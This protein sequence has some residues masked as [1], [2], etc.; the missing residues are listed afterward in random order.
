MIFRFTLNS[1]TYGALVLE[2][3]PAGWKDIEIAFKRSLEYHGVF[4]EA[5]AQLEFTC[6]AGKEY[7]DRAIEEEGVD[8]VIEIK[9]QIACNSVTGST[10]APDYSIDYSDDYGSLISGSG[11]PIFETL[12][13]GVLNLSNYKQT[14]N[15]TTV[16][17]V[18][19]DFVQKVL[20]R[21]DTTVEITK[22]ESLDGIALTPISDFPSDITLHSK[23]LLFIADWEAFDTTDTLLVA[24]PNDT[25]NIN[26]P[27][28]PVS[29]DIGGA[30]IFEAPYIYSYQQSGGARGYNATPPIFTNTTDAPITID[31]D[32][33][34]NAVMTVNN[35]L[36]S[37]SPG[38]SQMKVYLQPYGTNF[39]YFPEAIVLQ[40]ITGLTLSALSVPISVSHSGTYTIAAGEEVFFTIMFSDVQGDYSAPA[41]FTLTSF[42]ASDFDFKI[43]NNNVSEPSVAKIFKIHELGAAL[44]QRITSQEDAFR[45]ELLGRKN[46]EPNAYDQN[47]CGAFMGSL[48]GKLIRGFQV[49]DA[50]YFISMNNYFRTVNSL[51]STGL[52]FEKIGDQYVIRIE[53]KDY[54]Y[55]NVS[56]FQC[57]NVNKITTSVAKEYFVSDVYIGYEKWETEN[58]NGLDEFN[59]KRQY[60]DGVKAIEGRLNI[61]CPMIASMYSIEFARR[62]GVSSTDYRYDK[63][64]FIISLARGVDGSGNPNQLNIAEKNENFTTATGM[65]SPETSYNLRISP[66]R[67]LLWH[68]NVIGSSI[69]KF[70]NRAVKF[71]YGEGNFDV[72]TQTNNNCVNDFQGEPLSEKQDITIEQSGRT[73]I[74][75]P[76]Y[77]DFEYP[78]RFSEFLAIKA[79]PFG[80]IEASDTEENYI[81][82]FIIE[83]RYKPVFG[84]CTFRLL[85]KYGD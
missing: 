26:I 79:A 52:S 68:L 82:G 67:N 43:S 37:I 30:Q 58:I 53:G 25:V 51:L 78:L 63:D 35:S 77:I 69:T 56:M 61:E 24:A 6:K 48:N 83:M 74:W 5:M 27:M 44:S 23:T 75:I 66:A 11:A 10:E 31:I 80:Y 17:L 62:Q 85:K 59:T 42:I 2:R 47:G 9:I 18:Q 50:P 21:F 41:T 55:S 72:V 34:I 15:I 84:T 22:N 38:V 54:Y 20:N 7:I 1:E 19:S 36:G 76:E 49:S 14:N 46:S 39:S 64:N 65:R 8:S 16:D 57:A 45:S 71:V 13:E 40:N 3:D 28:I 4:Y 70:A 12:F 32:I 60:N 73:P 29:D 33:T 81:K